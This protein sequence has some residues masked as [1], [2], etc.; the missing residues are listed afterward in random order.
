MAIRMRTWLALGGLIGVVFG[1][2]GAWIFP[3]IGSGSNDSSHSGRCVRCA[4]VWVDACSVFVS[5]VEILRRAKDQ[6]A[7]LWDK[8]R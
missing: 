6:R 4:I 8:I 5:G 7:H 1:S 3:I 2:R